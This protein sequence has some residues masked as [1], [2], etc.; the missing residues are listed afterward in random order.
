MK[1]STR[2]NLELLGEILPEVCIDELALAIKCGA[3][4]GKH[5]PGPIECLPFRR[6]DYLLK[7]K[8]KIK[9]WESGDT[10]NEDGFV[11]MKIKPEVSNVKDYL[12][13]YNEDGTV[14]SQIPIVDTTTAETIVMVKDGYTIIIGGLIKDETT[15]TTKKVPILGDIP[16]LKWGFRQVKEEK[17]KTELVVFL[18]PHI[19]T[20]DKDMFKWEDK[21][22]KGLREYR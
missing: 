21:E 9:K 19:I 10:I 5:G 11:T 20:G 2:T 8:K 14:R 6:N 13:T 7:A 22:I 12:T 15:R 17:E 4:P 16:L 1:E 3:K 18:T